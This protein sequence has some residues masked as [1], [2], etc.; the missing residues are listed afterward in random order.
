MEIKHKWT[1]FKKNRSLEFCT[2]KLKKEQD[3]RKHCQQ[4]LQML[5]SEF[6]ESNLKQNNLVEFLLKLTGYN[7]DNVLYKITK[8]LSK[9]GKHWFSDVTIHVDK[10]IN[11]YKISLLINERLIKLIHQ[12]LCDQ[13]RVI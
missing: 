12:P 11:E 7:Y 2:K 8:R 4:L 1:S 3:F 10:S 5:Q 13:C 9:F 6:P